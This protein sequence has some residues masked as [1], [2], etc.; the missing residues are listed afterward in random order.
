MKPRGPGERGPDGP[1]GRGPGG[2]RPNGPEAKS[3]VEDGSGA[4]V[5]ELPKSDPQAP[6]SESKPDS[7]GSAAQPSE[8]DK[9]SFW[10]NNNY[11]VVN[12]P[13][14]HYDRYPNTYIV[15]NA[16]QEQQTYRPV[17]VSVGA[18][19]QQ[20]VPNR[21]SNQQWNNQQWNN[22]GGKDKNRYK[23]ASASEKK[24]GPPET[25]SISEAAKYYGVQV[26]HTPASS[27]VRKNTPVARDPPTATEVCEATC[28]SQ[29]KGG[30]T[31]L[32]DNTCSCLCQRYTCNART[33][34]GRRNVFLTGPGK[35]TPNNKAPKPPCCSTNSCT[36]ACGTLEGYCD[37]D[38]NC[39][40]VCP[41]CLSFD[42]IPC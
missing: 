27:G 14:P 35:A 22:H 24:R 41:P 38:G 33:V 10:G 23:D 5:P 40:C 17:D 37:P 2:P 9:K 4:P 28:A 12:Q 15:I 7:I 20:L 18:T 19:Y 13:G 21:P 3:S 42:P 34:S 30:G 26:V 36:A 29:N 6:L 25:N 16:T 31:V 32:P 39:I 1:G 11:Q 8:A